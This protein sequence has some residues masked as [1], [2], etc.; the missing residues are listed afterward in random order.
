MFKVYIYVY[1]DIYLYYIIYIYYIPDMLCQ[2]Y[3]Y[4][5]IEYIVV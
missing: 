1:T 4:N 2:I 5:I 3:Q